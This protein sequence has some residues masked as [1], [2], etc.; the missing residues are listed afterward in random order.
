VKLDLS[1]DPFLEVPP[2]PR[3]LRVESD[4]VAP[5][6]AARL[7]NDVTERLRHETILGLGSF[8]VGDAPD[9]SWQV[10]SLFSY[11]IAEHFLLTAGSRAQGSRDAD[12]DLTF[13]GPILGF[14][15]RF[16]GR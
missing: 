3:T 7:Q 14:G 10:T 12:L 1:L 4:W 9:L 13:H 2:Q 5:Y 11:A 8:G 16:G 15:L 6:L